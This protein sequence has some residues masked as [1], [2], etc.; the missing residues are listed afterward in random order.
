MI[1]LKQAV[2]VEGKYDKIRLENIIDATII[3]TEGFQIFK[4]KEKLDLIRVLAQKNGIIILTDSDRAGQMI[5]K[6]VEKSVGKAEIINV[7]LPALKGKEKRKTAPSKEGT[8]GVEGTDD[9]IIIEALRRV[10]VSGDKTEKQGR[11]ITKTDLFNLGLSGGIGSAEKRAD[12]LKYLSLPDFLPTNSLLS[13]LNSLYGY[14]DFIKEV[15]KW[16]RE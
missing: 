16:N 9:E 4:N 13:V 3:T 5:R 10:G 12:L 7:Y 15:E 14:N 1:K 2:I 8:L 11:K 6:H